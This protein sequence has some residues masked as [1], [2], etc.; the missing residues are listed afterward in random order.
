MQKNYHKLSPEIYNLD[1]SFA[2]IIASFTAII[3]FGLLFFA[4]PKQDVSTEE[5]RELQKFPDIT[6]NSIFKE[7]VAEKVSLYVND[8]FPLRDIFI[9]FADQLAIMRGVRVDDVTIHGSPIVPPDTSSSPEIPQSSSANSQSS[10]QISSS[11]EG[12]QSSDSSSQESIDAT[13]EQQGSTFICDDRAMGLFGY[14]K[15]MGKWYANTINKYS[16][17]LGDSVKIYNMVVPTSIDFYI[18]EKYKH[19]TQP[20]KPSIDNIYQYLNKKIAPVDAYSEIEKH[21]DEYIYFRTDH[22]WTGL[23]AYYAYV[24]FAK[25]AGFTPVEIK[26]FE[27]RRLDDFLGTLYALTKDKKLK[28]NPDYVDYYMISTPHTAYR[29]VKNAP[30]NPVESSI[31]GEYAVSP[32]SYSVFLHGD[33]PLTRIDT[34]IKNGRKIA[35]VKESYGNAFA[36]FLANHYEQV[37]IIDGRYF[38]LGFVDFIK[39]NGINELIFV[40]NTM[41]ANTPYHIKNLEKIMFQQFVPP[42]VETIKPVESSSVPDNSEQSADVSNSS[43]SVSSSESSSLSQEESEEREEK[44]HSHSD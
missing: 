39:Q 36:P 15:D 30:Y 33:F 28:E 23:G 2:N 26:D 25:E 13:G 31:H 35:V 40:N 14:N 24:A 4:L 37:F 9:S 11:S 6:L 32:N 8:H 29:Y 27:T 22:H 10:S 12:S 21:K 44:R 5:K 17:T 42:V 38:Q 7:R 41:A 34:N 3:F 19:L 18:P 16:D 43:S 1:I 20:Q